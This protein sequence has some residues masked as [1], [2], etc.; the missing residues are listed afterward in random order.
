MIKNLKHFWIKLMSGFVATKEGSTKKQKRAK[1]VKGS[2]DSKL[3]KDNGTY[4]A[5]VHEDYSN[6]RAEDGEANP[7]EVSLNK[8]E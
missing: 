5:N 3:W 8:E 7:L 2:T 1:L 6:D 4:Q